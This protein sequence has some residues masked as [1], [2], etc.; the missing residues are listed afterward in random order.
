MKILMIRILCLSAI[1]LQAQDITNKLG[2]NT[3]NETYDV[4]D[5]GDNLLFRVQGDG[6]VSIRGDVE[7]WEGIYLY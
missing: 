5:S 3:A 7:L 1:M 4:T 6:V 2:G